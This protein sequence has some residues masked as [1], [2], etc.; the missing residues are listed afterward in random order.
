MEL[1]NSV[2]P[3]TYHRRAKTASPEKA[4]SYVASFINKVA[5]EN[6]PSYTHE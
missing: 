5:A 2:F 6:E 1:S 3:R 4:A